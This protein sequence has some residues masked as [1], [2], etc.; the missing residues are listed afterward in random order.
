VTCVTGSVSPGKMFAF[1]ESPPLSKFSSAQIVFAE[2]GCC[3]GARFKTFLQGWR[4]FE[5]DSLSA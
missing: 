4:S 1:Q 2:C 3:Y 5:F